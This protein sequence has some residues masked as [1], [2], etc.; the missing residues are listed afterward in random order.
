MDEKTHNHT[1]INYSPIVFKI[2]D[3]AFIEKDA[4]AEG[5]YE[6]CAIVRL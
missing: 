4:L 1:C 5:S 2:S 3:D 6:E